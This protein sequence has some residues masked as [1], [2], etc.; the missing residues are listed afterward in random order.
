M[1]FPFWL[2][3]TIA[4]L[5]G[6]VGYCLTVWILSVKEDIDRK[7]AKKFKQTNQTR[8]LT[9][10]G[11]YTGMANCYFDINTFSGSNV[12]SGIAINDVSGNDVTAN[13]YDGSTCVFLVKDDKP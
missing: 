13:I 10:H 1:T 5:S 7:R 3:F 8:S 2:P 12:F 9:S 11:I 6:I 4:L